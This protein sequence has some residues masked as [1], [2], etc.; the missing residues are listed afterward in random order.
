MVLLPFPSF[1][2]HLQDLPSPDIPEGQGP[3]TGEFAEPD[4]RQDEGSWQGLVSGS[5]QGFSSNLVWLWTLSM[6]AFE[7]SYCNAKS[8]LRAF[9]FH[10]KEFSLYSFTLKFNKKTNV[11]SILDWWAYLVLVC[12]HYHY[13]FGLLSHWV[14]S[15]RRLHRRSFLGDRPRRPG[16]RGPEGST[17][18]RGNTGPWHNSWTEI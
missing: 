3:Q 5:R 15:C 8:I 2:S 13:H 18:L 4:V 16:W 11:A 12:F 9:I 1:W 7:K 10:W 6:S 14:G 17:A